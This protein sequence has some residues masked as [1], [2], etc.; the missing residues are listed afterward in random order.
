MER[1]VDIKALTEQLE[2][3][4]CPS[5]VRA[6]DQEGLIVDALKEEINDLT[7]RLGASNTEADNLREQ[8]VCAVASNTEQL[9]Q[10]ALLTEE[11]KK[12]QGLRDAENKSHQ[13]ALEALRSA[14]ENDMRTRSEEYLRIV[15]NLRED[16]TIRESECLD[17]T[18][19][20]KIDEG[21][22]DSGTTEL[23]RSMHTEATN[24]PA[25]FAVDGLSDP[26]L[27]TMNLDEL[28]A[29]Y[30]AL[31]GEYS[32]LV[33]ELKACETEKKELTDSFREF[34]GTVADRERAACVEYTMTISDLQKRLSEADGLLLLEQSNVRA[35]EK[36]L[37][38][39]KKQ[40][41]EL[42]EEMTVGDRMRQK[43]EAR[44]DTE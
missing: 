25:A 20:L 37:E 11:V 21:G 10:I 23:I 9:K 32:R 34:K 42:S 19:L 41:R 17:N 13:V 16:T 5:D 33:V 2:L 44:A 40:I 1:D 38:G 30:N 43:A 7:Y 27:K 26:A 28:R 18:T 4:R 6:G 29:A 31:S 8:Y 3:M 14:L 36:A 39:G 12:V 15:A 24:L 22:H 35:M